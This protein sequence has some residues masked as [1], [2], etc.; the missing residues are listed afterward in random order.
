MIFDTIYKGRRPKFVLRNTRF[1]RPDVAIVFAGA[2]VDFH[3]GKEA[4]AI[5]TLPTMVVAKERETWEIVAFQ[6]TR[7]TEMPAAVRPPE[8]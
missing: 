6:N 7:I 4:G 3:E 2:H 8:P 1:V 5:D